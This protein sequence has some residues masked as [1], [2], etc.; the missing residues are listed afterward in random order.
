MN[1]LKLCLIPF[2][3]LSVVACSGGG[4]GGGS[5]DSSGGGNNK[6]FTVSVDSIDVSRLGENVT[7]D[8]DDL[9]TNTKTYTQ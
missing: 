8:T 7:V 1:V 6:N 4:G 5:D 9:E 2:F 3:A